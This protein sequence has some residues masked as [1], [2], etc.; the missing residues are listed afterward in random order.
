MITEEKQ[1]KIIANWLL[2]G[3]GMLVVQVVLGGSNKTHGLWFIN[4]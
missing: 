4:Y 1:K 2:I 3:V